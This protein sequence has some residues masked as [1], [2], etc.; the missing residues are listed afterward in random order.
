MNWLNNLKVR[1]KLLLVLAV[2]V[3][4]FAIIAA[5]FYQVQQIDKQATASEQQSQKF[6]YLT[7]KVSELILQARRSEKDFLLRKDLEYV[8]R[9]DG[10]MQQVFTTIDHMD[11]IAATDEERQ[12]LPKVRELAASYQTTFKLMA[13][14]RVVLGLNEKVGLQGAF[15]NKVHDVE[16]LLKKEKAIDLTASMLMMRRHEKDFLLR[17][18]DKYPTRMAAE[19]KNFA[20]LLKTSKVKAT[21]KKI[22]TAAMADY[23]KGFLKLVQGTK[24]FRAAIVSYRK[25][26]HALD[27][28]LATL[29]QLS[30][31]T[32]ENNLVQVAQQ[33]NMA[34]NAFVI[35]LLVTVAT[36]FLHRHTLPRLF[37]FSIG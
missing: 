7:L 34:A 8:K 11:Q 19:Q 6:S 21:S 26:V 13:D 1:S 16:G 25:K 37:G 18:A 29:T 30:N 20:A 4:G 32:Y 22:I 28:E 27:P 24:D 12:V 14:T 17:E 10:I 31:E 2:L 36:T 3:V 35:T 15:R 33:R 9:H 5:V 23:Y